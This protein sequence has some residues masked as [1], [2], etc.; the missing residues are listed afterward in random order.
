[1]VVAVIF[2]AL[3]A[4]AFGIF[5]IYF[6][7][8]NKERMISMENGIEMPA[9]KERPVKAPRERRGSNSVKFTLKF[10]MFLIGLGVGFVI[11]VF[12]QNAVSDEAFP[13][14]VIGTVFIFGGLGLVSG[15]LIGMGI[16]KKKE[17]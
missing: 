2:I 12:L 5:Y 6:V 1:M 4:S 17:A 15:Y 8:R 10:G 9:L 3:F 16:D 13:L 7:T 11:A 14:A